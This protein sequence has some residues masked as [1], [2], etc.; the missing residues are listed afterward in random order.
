MAIPLLMMNGQDVIDPY[1]MVKT[2]GGLQGFHALCYEDECGCTDHHVHIHVAHG[3]RPLWSQSMILHNYILQL[4]DPS[5]DCKTSA[6]ATIYF[7]NSVFMCQ[8]VNQGQ[9]CQMNK[10]TIGQL[11]I[12]MQILF[13]ELINCSE[14]IFPYYTFSVNI[15][16]VL[17]PIVGTVIG[18]GV[19]C[20]LVGLWWGKKK[21][22][23]I[24]F[25][26]CS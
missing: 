26:M 10:Q 22:K 1:C 8:I 3:Q 19:L 13:T 24:S 7:S 5:S 11:Y 18:V 4:Q 6:L 16:V 23:Y 17:L 9:S 14:S 21:R 15:V 20:L 12:Y 2:H 25:N